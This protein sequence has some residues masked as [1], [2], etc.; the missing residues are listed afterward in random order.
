MVYKPGCR[1]RDC[2]RATASTT[3]L[4]RVL[5]R[6]AHVT[7]RTRTDRAEVPEIVVDLTTTRTPSVDLTSAPAVEPDAR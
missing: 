3:R 5:D 1:C 2:R 4:D 6:L 7:T